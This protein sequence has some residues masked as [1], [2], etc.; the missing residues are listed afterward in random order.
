M[1]GGGRIE[2]ANTLRGFAAISVMVSHYLG[3]FGPG[4]ELLAAIIHAPPLPLESQPVPAYSLWPVA[5]PLFSLPSFGVGLFFIISGF[6]IPFSLQKMDW[7]GFSIN[8]LFRIVPTYVVG[9]SL[10]LLALFLGTRY[11]STPWP[12]S[13]PE[14]LIHYVPGLRDVLGSSHIDFIVWTL[15]IEMKFYFLCAVLII[16]LRRYSL[17]AFGAPVALFLLAL[18]LDRMLPGWQENHGYLYGE[19]MVYLMSSQYIIFMF[20]GV[21]VHYLHRGKIDPAKAYFGIGGLFTLFC[22][23]WWAGPYSGTLVVA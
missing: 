9:F 1:Q 3:F 11:F 21:M 18:Y 10:T 8:R 20:I 6:V 23:H 17:K 2:F 5:F 14:M 4:R 13:L 19:S 7:L 12:F 15:E 16:W 22:L